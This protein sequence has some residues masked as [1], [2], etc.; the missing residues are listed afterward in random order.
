MT[1][2]RFRRCLDWVL[3][4][5]GGFNDIAADRGGATNHGISLRFAQG[6]GRMLDVDLD[7]HITS[8]DIRLLTRDQAAA[9]YWQH[10]WQAVRCEDLPKPLDLV[11]FC[12]AVNCG[13]PV[14]TRWV[15]GAV[16]VRADGIIGPLTHAA[17]ARVA[18]DA[19]LSAAAAQEVLAQRI[20][21][22]ASLGADQQRA[23]GLGWSRRLASLG[24][25]VGQ[26]I[27]EG[28]AT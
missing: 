4:W 15:Q 3:A 2:P 7:G 17:I 6:L 21:H 8:N 5:E 10:F 14:V 28:P 13:A 1:S 26:Q 24:I 18:A 16:G 25:E 27:A 23:F 22:H 20:R 12:S 9:V 19:R 11:A